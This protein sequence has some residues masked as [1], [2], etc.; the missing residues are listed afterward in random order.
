MRNFGFLMILMGLFATACG[1]EE[2]P[3]LADIV[4]GE[5]NL[6]SG[7]CIELQSDGTLIDLD[8]SLIGF[9]SNGNSA[10]IKTWALSGDTLTFR[11][12]I[13]PA[14][15]SGFAEITPVVTSFECDQMS[16]DFQIISASLD[17]K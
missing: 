2:C 5:W 4:V 1:D 11:A 9:D 6:N 17:R 13:D 14:L 10:D 7:G 8:D 15:G 16:L 12:E 3:V